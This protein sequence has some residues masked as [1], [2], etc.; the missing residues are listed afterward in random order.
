MKLA[1]GTAQ[2]GLDYG[3]SNADGKVDSSEVNKILTLA[4]KEGINTLDTAPAYGD[5]EKV[6]GCTQLTKAFNIVSKIPLLQHDE[7]NIAPYVDSSLKQLNINKLDAVLFHHADDI[8]SSSIAHQRFKSLMRQKELGN[9]NKIGISVYS[10]EQLEFCTKHYSIDIVQLPLSCIDQRFIESDWM[11][12][13]AN[14]NIEVHCRSLFLQGLL[15]V[16]PKD[17]PKNLTVF[18]P[19]FQRFEDTALQL[20]VSQLSLALAIKNQY[21]SIKKLVIGC[22]NVK[23]LSEIIKAYSEAKKITADLS[24]FSCKDENLII[25]SNWH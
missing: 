1:L 2:F 11:N 18:K 5:S 3:I 23:Q 7:I 17:L 16:K 14:K 21:P 22:C 12:K 8:I 13:L 15:L 20:K 19:Y 6:L 10:P 24:T 25:P 4:K 9:I